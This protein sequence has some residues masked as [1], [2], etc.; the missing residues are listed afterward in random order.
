MG[1]DALE[2]MESIKCSQSSL[3]AEEMSPL[4]PGFALHQ[5]FSQDKLEN[6][7]AAEKVSAKQGMKNNSLWQKLNPWYQDTLSPASIQSG[8]KVALTKNVDIKLPL[9]SL[10]VLEAPAQQTDPVVANVKSKNVMNV[11]DVSEGIAQLS[12]QTLEAV[13]AIVMRAQI[14]LDKEMA[15][16]TQTSYDQLERVNELRRR[17]LEEIKTEVAKDKNIAK[18]FNT[19]QK[20]AGVAV[21][22][23]AVASII[24]ATGLLGPA[25]TAATVL[26]WGSAITAVF[27]GVA[28]AGKAY[29]NYRTGQDESK[30]TLMNH[31]ETQT[32]L[33]LDN[34]HQRIERLAETDQ[35]ANEHLIKL[36]KRLHRMSKKMME[37]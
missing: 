15:A 19:A 32:N 36:C 11:K 8:E 6:V 27:S 12:T 26:A 5:V 9:Q 29:A 18:G 33:Y 4:K 20:V 14:E 21:G 17:T 30:F 25:G 1:I 28:T 34:I 31:Q 35:A 16:T 7:Q 2:P 13:L 3:P 23:C 10:P 37:N 22:V 24:V